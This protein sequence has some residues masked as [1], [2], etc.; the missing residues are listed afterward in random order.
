MFLIGLG[1]GIGKNRVSRPDLNRVK[2]EHLCYI[3][4]FIHKTIGDNRVRGPTFEP[5]KCLTKIS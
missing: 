5:C 2:D 1:F 3:T 4:S